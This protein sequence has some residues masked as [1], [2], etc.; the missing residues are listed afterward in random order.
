MDNCALK[1]LAGTTHFVIPGSSSILEVSPTILFVRKKNRHG[2]D[3][4]PK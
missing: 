2:R 1:T 4:V 3:P